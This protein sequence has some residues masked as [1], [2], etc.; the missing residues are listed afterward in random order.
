[1]LNSPSYLFGLFSYLYTYIKNFE[2][3]FLQI[4]HLLLTIL[5]F[6]HLLLT[7]LLLVAS[8]S[9]YLY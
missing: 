7:T 1:M 4:V 5:L 6:V 9:L 3:V 2:E 8:C